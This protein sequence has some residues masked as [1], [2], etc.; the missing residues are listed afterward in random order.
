[1]PRLR[2]YRGE[3]DGQKGLDLESVGEDNEDRKSG[4]STATLRDEGLLF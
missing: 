2:I 4:K 3:E 1:M